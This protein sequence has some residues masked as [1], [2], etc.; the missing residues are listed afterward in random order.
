VAMGRLLLVD[1][2]WFDRICLSYV[3]AEHRYMS[4]YARPPDFD[5]SLCN[6]YKTCLVMMA[7]QALAA[8]PVHPE[9]SLASIAGQ[10]I[11]LT[12][13]AIGGAIFQGARDT[14]LAAGAM[15]SAVSL[16]GDCVVRG[17]MV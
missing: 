14:V 3:R 5:L 4:E 1:A 17:W 7:C 13:M 2:L 15:D 11:V 6:R 16:A 10:A 9:R 8:A 12:N